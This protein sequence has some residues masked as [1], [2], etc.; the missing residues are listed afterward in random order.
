[1]TRPLFRLKESLPPA[2]S[3]APLRLLGGFICADTHLGCQGCAFC[4]NRRYPPLGDVLDRDIQRDFADIGCPPEEIARHIERLPMFQRARV[5]LRLAH[6]TDLAFESEGIAQILDLLPPDTPAVLL[7]RRPLARSFLPLIRARSGLLVHA[8][9][10]P[11]ADPNLHR[12]LLDSLRDVPPRQ[13]FIR[14]SPLMSGRQNEARAIL[15]LLPQGAAVGFGE[16]KTN[17]IPG[18]E[19]LSSL[20]SN[21]IDALFQCARA[22]GL[23]PLDYFGCQLRALIQRPFFLRAVVQQNNPDTCAGCAN[24]SVCGHA[25]TSR[26]IS[27]SEI[28]EEAQNIGLKIRDIQRDGEQILL[29]TDMPTGRADEV[30]LSE[31]F[32]QQIQLSTIARGPERGVVN[33]DPAIFDRWQSVG[34]YPVARMRE[35]S[36][37]M[38]AQCQAIHG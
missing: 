15:D 8:S 13:I 11:G 24:A 7:T 4:L 23:T 19:K 2:L 38:L 22:Q 16:L 26:D 6:L 20:E 5:P 31:Y 33:M 29:H 12:A 34:F 14:L 17:G 9:M 30:H 21:A 27:D 28:I 37:A 25:P 1:M 36:Q 18:T 32:S 3:L 10:T 35:I